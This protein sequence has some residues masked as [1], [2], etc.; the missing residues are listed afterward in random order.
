MTSGMTMSSKSP[1]RNPQRPSSTPFLTPLLDTLLIEISKRNFQGIVLGVKNIIHD[2]RNNHFLH[3]SGQENSM[4]SK[5]PLL[6]PL[7]LP[8]TL[9]LRYQH[10][11]FRVSSLGYKNIIHDVSYDPVLHVSGQKPSTSSKYP[12][13]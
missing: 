3:V 8:D 1:V 11:I 12:P 9:Q 2:V 5:S 4:S 6:D 7:P 13:S 10:K